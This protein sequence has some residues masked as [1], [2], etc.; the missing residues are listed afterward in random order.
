MGLVE[1]RID[2]ADLEIAGAG[3]K[4]RLPLDECT[5]EAALGGAAAA[6]TYLVGTAVG[7]GLG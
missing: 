1:A 6:L 4:R 5:A 2:N 7:A 3:C